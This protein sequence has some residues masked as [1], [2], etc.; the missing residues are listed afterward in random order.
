MVF[1]QGSCCGDGRIDCN[2]DVLFVVRVEGKIDRSYD[3]LC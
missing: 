1:V 3:E 2:D